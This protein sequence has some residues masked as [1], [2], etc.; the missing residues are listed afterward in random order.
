MASAATSQW[1]KYHWK[2]VWEEGERRAGGQE[3]D[4][5]HIEGRGEPGNE[6]GGGGGGG[7]RGGVRGKRE[8]EEWCEGRREGKG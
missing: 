4:V 1:G 3:H 6:S 5:T 7:E 8:E 2:W